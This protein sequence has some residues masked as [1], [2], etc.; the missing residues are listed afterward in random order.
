MDMVSL[1]ARPSLRKASCCRVEVMKGAGGG[2]RRSRVTTFSTTELLP[3]DGRHAGLGLVLV[4]GLELLP[5]QAGEPRQEGRRVLGRQL[6]PHGPVLLGHEGGDGALALH[7][8]AQG[9]RLHAPRREPALDL[10][11]QDGAD[12]IAHQAVQHPAGLLA[13]VEVLVSGW[14]RPRPWR[15]RPWSARGRAP[16]DS[17]PARRPAARRCARRWPRPRGRGRGPGRF[18]GPWR[19]PS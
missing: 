11:P 4:G 15:W 17:A 6:G 16:G 7:H 12:L 8:Q 3:G 10:V 13:V 2:C 19:R 14:G 1:G 5:G 9:H 18:P